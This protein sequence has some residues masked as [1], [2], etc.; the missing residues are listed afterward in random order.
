MCSLEFSGVIPEHYKQNQ[1][2]TNK[3][4]KTPTYY[5]LRLHLMFIV[6]T[7]VPP[8]IHT[9]SS[10]PPATLLGN[11]WNLQMLLPSCSYTPLI[12]SQPVLEPSQQFCCWSLRAIGQADLRNSL[13]TICE[14]LCDLVVFVMRGSKIEPVLPAG[15]KAG[16]VELLV[17]K[18]ALWKSNLI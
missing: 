15:R 1:I 12:S 10:S 11:V 8:S 5:R 18:F 7:H 16:K 3:Q 9:L 2:P 4:N 17:N 6:Y 14:M 13:L